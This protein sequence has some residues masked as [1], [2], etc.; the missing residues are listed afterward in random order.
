MNG[1]VYLQ[2]FFTTQGTKQAVREKG[3]VLACDNPEAWPFT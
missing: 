3:G 2:P 1:F